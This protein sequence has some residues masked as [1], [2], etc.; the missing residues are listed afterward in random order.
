MWHPDPAK[1]VPHREMI[2]YIRHLPPGCQ[3]DIAQ[4]GEAASWSLTDH[5]LRATANSVI[6][7]NYQR[8]GKR[9]PAGAF[10]P[11]PLRA[12]RRARAGHRAEGDKPQGVD[13]L[14]AMFDKQEGRG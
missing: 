11:D 2:N 6:A 1:R 10:I 5:L 9:A 14:N 4:R 13:E 8:A 7:G 12:T 3:L